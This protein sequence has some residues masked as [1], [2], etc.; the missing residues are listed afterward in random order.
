M[1]RAFPRLAL[2]ASHLGGFRRWDEVAAQLVGS[3]VWLDTSYTIGRIPEGLLRE[4][5]LGHRPDRLLFGS[6]SPW[7]D[8]TTAVAALRALKLPP[9]LEG[10]V[11]GRNALDL[12]G[13]SP[14]PA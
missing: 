8:Q 6:D 9:D 10:G 7:E 13:I 3:G 11:L 2:V 5:L 14:Q 1:H 12:L 4:I